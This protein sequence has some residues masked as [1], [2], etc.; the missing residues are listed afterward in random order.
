MK[1]LVLDDNKDRLKQF[2]QKL[3]GHVVECAETAREAIELLEKNEPFDQIFLDHDL[4]GFEHQP[5]GKNTGYEVAEWISKHNH[6][7]PF[8]I[9]IHSF[10]VQGAQNILTLLPE[11]SYIPGV[12]LLNRMEF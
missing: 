10:N 8:R 4:S 6:K 2:K 9:V 12:W 7:R 5:S 3:I 11:A 1:I